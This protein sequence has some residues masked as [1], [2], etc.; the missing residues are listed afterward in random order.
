M[1]AGLVDQTCGRGETQRG[2]CRHKAAEADVAEHSK[3]ACSSLPDGAAEETGIWPS[4]GNMLQQ[5]RCGRMRAGLGSSACSFEICAA[6]GPC[7]RPEHRSDLRV[8]S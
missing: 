2:N 5:L 7:V 4:Q 8:T 1:Q 6:A 3:G